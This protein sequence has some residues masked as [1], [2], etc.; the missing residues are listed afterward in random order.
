MAPGSLLGATLNWEVMVG[1]GLRLHI[2]Q[3]W[4]S[5]ITSTEEG[6]LLHRGQ[7]QICQHLHKWHCQRSSLAP[8]DV[9]MRAMKYNL[10]VFRSY[11]RIL[12][13]SALN[14]KEFLKDICLTNLFLLLWVTT[15]KKQKEPLIISGIINLLYGPALTFEHEME[16][17][18]RHVLVG[19][20][21]TSL[22]PLIH[23]S[24]HLACPV[25]YPTR[26][27]FRQDRQFR[28]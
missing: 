13:K 4:L 17:Q 14:F 27:L 1:E 2:W 8:S 10:R 5:L 28:N 23:H 15:G 21:S 22:H 24:Y 18:R 26:A 12:Q 3:L 7:N 16:E 20:W 19:S 6:C 11:C 9:L 25:Q